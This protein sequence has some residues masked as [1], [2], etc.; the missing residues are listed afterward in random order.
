V[1]VFQ[2][3]LNIIPERKL[4]DKLNLAFWLGFLAIAVSTGRL[5][6]PAAGRY[7]KEE[8]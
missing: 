8:I 1:S 2:E 3:I 5:L 6:A 7:T 4:P